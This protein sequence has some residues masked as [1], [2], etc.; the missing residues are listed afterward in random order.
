ME[1]LGTNM[2]ES[3]LS[4][5]SKST[6]LLAD[7]RSAER[8]CSVH[9]FA[10]IWLK[11]A[12]KGEAKSFRDLPSLEYVLAKSVASSLVGRTY[13]SNPATESWRK[14]FLTTFTEDPEMGRVIRDD[15]RA[16]KECNPA[17]KNRYVDCFRSPGF[18]VLQAYRVA[19]KFWSLNDKEKAHKIQNLASMAFDIDIHPGAKIGSGIFIDYQGTTVVIGETAV[20]GD[21]VSVVDQNT[22]F[23]RRNLLHGESYSEISSWAGWL[24]FKLAK[25]GY[26][27]MDKKSLYKIIIRTLMEDQE[28]LRDVRNVSEGRGKG[29]SRYSRGILAYLAYKV[30]HKLLL[31]DDKPTALEIQALASKAFE[32][33]IH[34][35][36][37]LG[38]GILIDGHA[39]AVLIRETAIVRDNV[40]LLDENTY[41]PRENLLAGERYDEI[42][43]LA[44]R[45]ASELADHRFNTFVSKMDKKSLYTVILKTLIQDH[46][47][48]KAIRDDQ[49][50]RWGWHLSSNSVYSRGF[51]ACLAY[52]VALKLWSQGD[53]T[54]V[55]TIEN[56]AFWAFEVG[57]GILR[58]D[59]ATRVV[60][61]KRMVIGQNVTIV[62]VDKNF[63]SPRKKSYDVES[64]YQRI[65]L[66]Q[67]ETIAR[68]RHCH[69][70]VS[71]GGGYKLCSLDN[72]FMAH[73]IQNTASRGFGFDIRPVASKIGRRILIDDDATAVFIRRK[74]VN[75][76]DVTTGDKNFYFLGGNSNAGESYYRMSSQKDHSYGIDLETSFAGGLHQKCINAL[77]DNEPTAVGSG[78]SG[79]ESSGDGDGD[80]DFHAVQLHQADHDP[81]H[82]IELTTP[83]LNN[84][85]FVSD[86]SNEQ[87]PPDRFP[88]D[89]EMGA[90]I[91]QEEPEVDLSGMAKTMLLI[92]AEQGLAIVATKL[93]ASTSIPKNTKMLL[94]PAE[95]CSVAGFLFCSGG[96]ILQR[97]RRA[98]SAARL[99]TVAG[100]VAA[101]SGFILMMACLIN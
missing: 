56:M 96:Y 15:L 63:N 6:R 41:F 38:R 25:Y 87:P 101:I 19:H 84:T 83:G 55:Q 80:G 53:K 30:A 77:P 22:Y 2:T 67:A 37:K 17:R 92:S 46:K 86:Q 81:A 27:K 49:G 8:Y 52:V 79:G 20:I 24:A 95:V 62:A 94:F 93:G 4:P 73:K 21:N 51:L 97:S 57:R 42:S 9:D 75:G 65:M 36:A 7:E 88:S 44:D 12:S 50:A 71:E 66:V 98:K 64:L 47:I 69:W 32:I 26:N 78:H 33:D 68:I 39:T 31:L 91:V 18:L 5:F 99:M 90:E 74:A 29:N 40:I 1:D 35:G 11:M 14:V 3:R 76:D 85:S 82:S 48:R 34:P 23:F 28:I 58:H 70:E 10:E 54:M 16:E 60:T 100:A 61:G 59:H 13:L 72:K 43:S 89:I 45:L